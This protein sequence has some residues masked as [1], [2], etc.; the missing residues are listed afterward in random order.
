VFELLE[1]VLIQSYLSL[2]SLF[3]L[4]YLF[5]PTLFSIRL[6]PAMIQRR[7]FDRPSTAYLMLGLLVLSA[8]LVS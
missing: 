2:T 4:V 6:C 3:D 1:D 7:T 5:A 8:P